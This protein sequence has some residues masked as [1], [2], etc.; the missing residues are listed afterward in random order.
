[1]VS[2]TW[3][4]AGLALGT[5]AVGGIAGAGIGVEFSGGG[6]GDVAEL[7]CPG[8]MS[9][10]AHV[11]DENGSVFPDDPPTEI[12]IVATIDG[13]GYLVEKLTT[14]VHNGTHIDA[15]GHFVADGRTID[16]L[17]AEEF[18]WP[19]YVIDVRS[20]M[21][22]T[23]A[24][25]DIQLSV[26]DIK[27]IE[28]KQGKIPRGALVIL[29]TGFDVLFGTPEYDN[30]V[31]GFSAAA[32]QWMVDAR[33]ID[34]IGSDT[35]GP[36]ATNDLDFSATATILANDRIAMPDI[37]NL[38]RVNPTGDLIIAPAVPLRDGSAFMVEPL[39]CHRD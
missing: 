14:G 31:P 37:A 33:R 36:D 20:R 7:E 28:R 22:G 2:R 21:T 18:V 29:R 17:A 27:A 30:P 6:R 26:A 16:D 35:Y 10:L 8:G 4:G 23:A 38:D 34:G 11:F 1:M 9:R 15:P 39:A 3:L 25:G 12:E 5:F 32:V 24:D 13:Q 19:A